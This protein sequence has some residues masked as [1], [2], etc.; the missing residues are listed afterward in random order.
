MT[1]RDRI[2]VVIVLVAAAVVGV[3]LMVIQPARDRDA[4]LGD[5][6]SA[7]QSQVDTARSQLLQARLAQGSYQSDFA[8][9]ARLGEAVPG[10]DEVPS[11][12]YELQS[13][14]TGARVDFRGLSASTSSVSATPTAPTATPTTTGTQPA[15]LPPYVSIGANGFPSEQFTFT[16]TGTY[17]Q[18]AKFLD[19][20][21]GFVTVKGTRVSVRGR[22]ISV[23]SISLAASS[24]GF[25]QILATITANTYLMPSTTATST[26]GA[27]TGTT[28]GSTA[29]ASAPSSGS[30]TAAPAVA[31]PVK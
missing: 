17:F 9:L 25:P 6:V 16:F 10:D 14:A 27:A 19:R 26:P 12:I 15:A 13:A 29:T 4:K 2:V 31:T 22:L 1:A 20:V 21:Q 18:L 11:L 23:T 5:Q 28:P 7:I 8:Q 24:R 3:W 30:S